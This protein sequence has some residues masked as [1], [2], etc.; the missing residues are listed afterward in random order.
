MNYDLLGRDE[1]ESAGLFIRLVAPTDM[2][3]VV[4]RLAQLIADQYS[5]DWINPTLTGR[6]G[7]D[8]GRVY[9]FMRDYMRTAKTLHN[10]IT[11]ESYPQFFDS[12]KRAYGDKYSDADLA[13]FIPALLNLS[14]TGD[15]PESILKP[16]D[17]EEVGFIAD[18]TSTAGKLAFSP[19]GIIAVLAIGI[20][21]F[22]KGGFSKIPKLFS[23]KGG[24]SLA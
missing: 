3:K 23:G 16:Y 4:K 10:F 5:W 1:Q 20:Y 7:F 24:P 18:V 9:E 17:Y 6:L 12:M 11:R 22:G 15:I 14:E 21:A 2:D 13:D 19:V 8:S